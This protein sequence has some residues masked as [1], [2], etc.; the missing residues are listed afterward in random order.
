MFSFVCNWDNIYPPSHQTLE[1][2]I[3]FIKIFWREEEVL[4]NYKIS[5][6]I[7]ENL[8]SWKEKLQNGKEE[9]INIFLFSWGSP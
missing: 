4:K 5:L 8:N 2:T 9:E 6:Q 3:F 1:I 7:C